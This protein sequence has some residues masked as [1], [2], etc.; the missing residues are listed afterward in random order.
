MEAF[1][2]QGADKDGFVKQDFTKEV[3]VEKEKEANDA[4]A[5]KKVKSLGAVKKEKAE[6]LIVKEVIKRG[7]GFSDY[8]DLFKYSSGVCGILAISILTCIHLG[9]LMYVGYFMS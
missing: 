9:L 1:Q 2:N 8:W 7:I 4:L 6:D 3:K 5:I